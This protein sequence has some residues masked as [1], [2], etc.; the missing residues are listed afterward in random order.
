MVDN[1]ATRAMPR[2]STSSSG[3][4]RFRCSRR[5]DPLDLAAAAARSK[6]AEIAQSNSALSWPLC[7][8][9]DRQIVTGLP[10][11]TPDRHSTIFAIQKSLARFE[12]STYESGSVAYP[13]N[14]HD[15]P[16]LFRKRTRDFV[17]PVIRIAWPPSSFSDFFGIGTRPVFAT[18][19]DS[20]ESYT[21]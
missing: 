10:A 17:Y 11:T 13:P 2:R 9:R 6:D 21:E 20:N 3:R 8:H 16:Q 12:L 18:A 19:S 1:C 14:A 5:S 15:L 4:R 7:A